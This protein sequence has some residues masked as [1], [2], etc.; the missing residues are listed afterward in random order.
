MTDSGDQLQEWGE[1][2]TEIF[3]NEVEFTMDIQEPIEALLE[4]AN[5]LEDHVAL[6]FLSLFTSEFIR[7][8]G[9]E[10]ATLIFPQITNDPTIQLLG[11]AVHAQHG[12]E[13]G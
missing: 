10:A 2:L 3:P 4:W 11:A 9:M 6:I 12:E 7:R 1:R 8:Y 13:E 5:D